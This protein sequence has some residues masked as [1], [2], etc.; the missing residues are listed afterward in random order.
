MISAERFKDFKAEH[1]L[2]SLQLS[3]LESMIML[4]GGCQKKVK[5]MTK[6][7]FSESYYGMASLPFSLEV[8]EVTVS[9]HAHTHTKTAHYYSQQFAFFMSKTFI[10]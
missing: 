6:K 4:N 3:L 1:V 8:S 7:E 9:S 10:G 2:S 5:Y